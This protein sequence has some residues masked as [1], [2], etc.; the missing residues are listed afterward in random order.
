LVLQFVQNL[1][2]QVEDT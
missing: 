1:T 2:D